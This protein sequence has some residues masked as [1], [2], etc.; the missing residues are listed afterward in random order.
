MTTRPPGLGRGPMDGTNQETSRAQVPR[1]GPVAGSFGLESPAQITKPRRLHALTPVVLITQ[2]VIPALVVAGFDLPHSRTSQ[3]STSLLVLLPF[4]AIPVAAGIFGAVSW[5][6][7][8][9]HFEAGELRVDS[10]IAFR[11]S[12]RVRLDRMQA[13][14]VLQPFFARMFGL[15]ELRITTAGGSR[16]SL[17]LRY[18]SLVEARDLR[19]ELLGQAAGL[20]SGVKEAP[21]QPLVVVPHSMLVWSSILRLLP[22]WVVLLAGVAALITARVASQASASMLAPLLALVPI[23]VFVSGQLFW[24]RVST[25]WGFTVAESPDGLRLRHGLL[26]IRSQTVPPGRV[27][28]LKIHQP[29][30]WRMFGWAEV[31]M[32]VA[33]Y[34]G[35]GARSKEAPKTVLLPVA[36]TAVALA[37]AGRLVG[38]DIARVPM[39]RPPRR[40]AACAPLWWKRMGVGRD[41]AIFVT[42]HGLVSRSVDVVRHERT[43]S[44]RLTAGPWQR[45]WR[46]ATVHLDSAKG[47]VHMRAAFRDSAEARDILYDQADRARFARRYAVPDR[48]MQPQTPGF[49]T[50]DRSAAQRGGGTGRGSVAGNDMGDIG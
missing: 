28:A 42:M 24:R 30:V 6:V 20:G 19:A 27:Q 9:F 5:V 46:L 43:Q 49:A 32:N 3:A 4:L 35:G 7:T 17:R 50:E 8:R 18:L 2:A 11:Q 1:P 16:R 37:L 44:V 23:M 29:L 39:R 36:P 13:V 21:E 15:A 26:S 48:W 34:S 22:V 25:W 38:A 40:A 45:A 31:M 12:K 41:D 14:D 47:P 33:G 10:G